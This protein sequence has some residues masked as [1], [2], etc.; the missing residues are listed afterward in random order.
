MF[1]V[2]LIIVI[3]L[4]GSFNWIY[5]ILDSI[6]L[7]AFLISGFCVYS[8]IFIPQISLQ[9]SN[10]SFILHKS[11]TWSEYSTQRRHEIRQKPQMLIQKLKF[12]EV[13]DPLI[14]SKYQKVVG[15]IILNSSRDFIQSWWGKLT[16]SQMFVYKVE[17]N[18]WNVFNELTRRLERTDFVGFII[19]KILPIFTMHLKEVA[20]AEKLARGENVRVDDVDNDIIRIYK[21]G[22]IHPA[23][24]VK[25]SLN[26]EQG[27]LR[28]LFKPIIPLLLSKSEGDVKIVTVLLR[29]ILICKIIQPILDTMADSDFWN[30]M[31]DRLAEK[32][33]L[34]Y[35][36][37]KKLNDMDRLE[38]SDDELENLD[39]VNRP[40]T[41]D[42]FIKQIKKCDNLLDAFG[43]RD[44][45]HKE[46]IKKKNEIGNLSLLNFSWMWG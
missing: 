33:M 29:E 7:L 39:L 44:T 19:Y 24:S 38:R 46:I 27:Y 4:F 22:K 18:L 3:V 36:L 2:G 17:S 25:D 31:F 37:D 35:S 14:V 6:G 8:W 45:I 26:L 42:N 13:M 30:L 16:N 1:L 43:I 40:P 11:K 10:D 12:R 23:I 41:F 32:L 15:E 28:K 21:S 34:E 20:K 9:D 5:F